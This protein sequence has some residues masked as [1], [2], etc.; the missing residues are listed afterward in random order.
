MG[1][2]THKSDGKVPTDGKRSC[3]KQAV[4]SDGGVKRPVDVI[5][6]SWG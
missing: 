1:K 5:H 4:F 3:S 2:Y 6:V